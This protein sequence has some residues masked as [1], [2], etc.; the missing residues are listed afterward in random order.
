MRLTQKASLWLALFTAGGFSTLPVSAQNLVT[1]PGFE[2]GDL[3]GYMSSGSVFLSLGPHIGTYAAAFNDESL[4][5]RLSQN[6]P[7]VVGNTYNVSFFLRNRITDGSGGVNEFQASFAG[8]Q[9]VDVVSTAGF[10]YKQFSFTSVAAGPTSILLF[11]VPRS[12]SGGFFLDDVSIT[13]AGAPVPEASSLASLGLLL[14][15]GLG[16]VAVSRRRRADA[17]R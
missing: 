3:T 11:S 8:F 16:G 10:D 5:A 13:D 6:I 14:L 1:N 9:G 12:S 17:A 15:L 4:P 2:T 7:T